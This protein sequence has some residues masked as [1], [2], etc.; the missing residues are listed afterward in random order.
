MSER[1]AKIAVLSF[2]LLFICPLLF[3]SVS[4][5]SFEYSIDSLIID[6]SLNYI[7]ISASIEEKFV[8]A[9]EE[10]DLFLFELLPSDSIKDINSL[11]PLTSV[12]SEKNVSEKLAYKER[13]L[14]S[15]FVFAK[16]NGDGTYTP[17]SEQ[18][19]IENPEIFSQNTLPFPK[20]ATKKGL[21][22]QIASD[23]QYLGAAHTII[24]TA[25]EEYMAPNQKE[26]TIAYNYLGQTFY[27][28]E[29]KLS[30]LD[31]K[32]KTLTESGMNIYFNVVLGKNES[33]DFDFIYI[34]KGSQ[35]ASLYAINTTS[36][37]AS[38]YFMAFSK[39]MTE[40]Y[41]SE[42]TEN[43]F[44]PGYILGYEVNTTGIWNHAGD[45][46]FD[47]YVNYYENA[48]RILY[49]ALKSTYANG[50]VYVSVSNL[51]NA[52]E[53]SSDFG[54]KAFLESFAENVR[55][56]GDISWALAINPYPSDPSLTEF[57]LDENAINSLD[58][59]YLT[60]K[61]L[62]VL[63]EFMRLDTMTYSGSVRDIIISELGINGNYSDARNNDCQ[64]GAYALAYAIADKNEDI[65]AFIYYRHV[66]HPAEPVHLGLWTS[67][68]LTALVP[69]NKKAIYDVFRN[70]DTSK[71]SA[72]LDIAR[73]FCTDEVY[74]QLLDDY[75]PTAKKEISEAIPV[76][77]TD[78]G[79]T[80]KE[81]VLFDL[82]GGEL[83]GFYPSDNTSYV[84]LRPISNSEYTTRLY[85]S[86]KFP[87]GN[88]YSG[89]S[90]DLSGIELDRAEYITISFK[91]VTPT[92]QTLTVMLR[93]DSHNGDVCHSFEGIVQL[94]SNE[95]SELTFKISDYIKATHGDI[96]SLKLLYKPTTASIESG[97]YGLW[98]ESI[99]VHQRTGLTA[100]VTIII[101]IVTVLVIL[102][103]I[104]LT[105]FIK[106][107]KTA[108]NKIKEITGK[109][110][111]RIIGLLKDK[112]IISRRRN[113]KKGA[114][115]TPP[116][117]RNQENTTAPKSQA[118][119]N[120]N[121]GVRI[122]NGRVMP[123][124]RNKAQSSKPIINFPDNDF[125]KPS[126]KNDN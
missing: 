8:D 90:K 21:C 78:I 99:T 73:A 29:K 14:Y 126:D 54:T 83:L 28:Y 114:K 95:E 66:D 42:D 5:E 48:Y 124:P 53:S 108:Q 7:E 113:K 117:D 31:H 111:S 84:E 17:V 33:G 57:W 25:I 102:A 11:A 56:K 61:N 55:K 125:S 87:S 65:D 38:R 122:V 119:S 3:V 60:M 81:R 50:R 19:Y 112:K 37:Q 2:V 64:A 110:K 118:K 100:A 41:S 94:S 27:F 72:G 123:G 6:D 97:E 26:G 13:M 12:R 82:T 98:L 120:R 80:Y 52:D 92:P 36:L 35:S 24:N 15:S 46:N 22:T 40:R 45:V 47:D 62:D 69:E 88:V 107:N 109:T 104:A 71:A 105:V 79:S 76:L 70:A 34:D 44:V 16:K 67:N 59:P 32:V 39:F 63:S 103:L 96:D 23:A 86:Q 68:A 75:T 115:V 30:A 4:A 77:K 18:K 49:S 106:L 91:P 89:I 85:S 58:T 121:S 20:R 1:L 9:N 116:K 101:T 74:T 10:V 51:F 93:L 43:G